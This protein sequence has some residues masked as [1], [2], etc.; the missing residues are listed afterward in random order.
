MS[1]PIQATIDFAALRHNHAL[2]RRHAG[3]ARI[4]TVVKANAYGHGLLRV[5]RALGATADGYALIELDGAIALRQ[6]GVVQPILMLEG[7]YSAEE[8]PL[9]A[10]QQLIPVLHSQ[11]QLRMLTAASLPG[12]LPVHLKLNT[13]MNRLG[14]NA[15]ELPAVEALLHSKL[16]RVPLT[17]LVELVARLEDEHGGAIMPMNVWTAS[18]D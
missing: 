15:D 13:G 8:L 3:G 14:F 16:A 6:Q 12:P 5:A 2:A 11:A 18:A 9:F 10:Q 17:G 4:W 1:R 7:F